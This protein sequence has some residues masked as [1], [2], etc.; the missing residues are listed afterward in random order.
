MFH[1]PLFLKLGP[2]LKVKGLF[3]G[4]GCLLGVLFCLCAC[5]RDKKQEEKFINI[6]VLVTEEGSYVSFEK[7][8]VDAI[9]LAIEEL[10]EQGGLLGRK[11]RPLIK[12]LEPGQGGVE[13]KVES[14]I[15]EDEVPILFAPVTADLRRQI[16]PIVEKLN[17]LMIF[18]MNFEGGEASPNIVYTGLSPNQTF[19]PA[20]S[21]ASKHIG[22]K[23]FLIGSSSIFSHL[24]HAIVKDFVY[25]IE[26]EVV[27]EF[28]FQV[29]KGTSLEALVEAVNLAEPKIII[30]T[31]VGE[32]NIDF[33][34]ALKETR[35]I[36]SE[37]PVFSF[38]VTEDIV[39][40][41]TPKVMEGNYLVG[42]YFPSIKSARNLKFVKNFN[43]KFGKNQGID[44]FVATAYASVH[45]WA[46]AVKEV[47]MTNPV[48][49]LKMI[50]G[51]CLEAP[52]GFLFIDPASNCAC[53]PVKIAKIDASGNSKILWESNKLIIPTPFPL[54][55]TPQQ[56][57]DFAEDLYAKWGRK[58]YG[59]K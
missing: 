44:Q 37:V 17:H 46:N 42:S 26:G 40:Y 33:F 1:K 39:K 15:T 11:L 8:I 43:A 12:R 41:L 58:W 48:K 34:Q 10:N 35:F 9:L 59:P 31:L 54:F 21:W 57:V 13:E 6:G 14:L 18:P 16:K 22:K 23:F 38:G 25:S 36:P 29:D 50:R 24:A 7:P 19:L 53:K 20:V 32:S 4:I 3:V 56:W 27:G 49:V 55:R 45:L 52:G 47:R 51:Q 5:S 28:F 2:F 30:N